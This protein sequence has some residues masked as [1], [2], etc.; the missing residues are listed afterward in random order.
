MKA[1]SM[2]HYLTLVLIVIVTFGSNTSLGQGLYI[3]NGF[4]AFAG[5]SSHD[6]ITTLSA[7]LG[8]VF[9]G[10]FEFGTT[11]AVSTD[12]NSDL[13]ALGIAPYVSLYPIRQSNAIPFTA[14]LFATYEFE[15]FS[16][17][18]IDVLN[19]AGIEIS[20]YAWGVGGV[21]VRSFQASPVIQVIP[22]AGVSYVRATVKAEVF[23][24]T[25][26]EVNG[27]TGVGISLALMID[28][29]PRTAFLIRPG[30]T[31][32]EGDTIFGISI[33]FIGGS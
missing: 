28:A 30:V 33:G 4:G 15:S 25:E 6:D 11:V 27:S 31:F 22:S 23:G 8:Y 26:E 21:V 1:H 16:G 20:G 18:A 12:D 24:E 13:T 9:S 17:D 32:R 5:F 3:S 10:I 7:E 29:S 19:D 14:G 2:V